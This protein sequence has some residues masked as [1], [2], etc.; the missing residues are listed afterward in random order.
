MNERVTNGEAFRQLNDEQKAMFRET[1]RNHPLT[2]YI[3]WDAF[4][5]SE[6]GNALDFVK[7]IE[8]TVDESGNDVFFLERIQ[9]DDMDY[10]LM[11]VCG[12]NIFVKEPDDSDYTSEV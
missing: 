8:K 12:E 4:Y 5:E 11:F 2:D 10:K 1:Y 3:D 9:E 7:C 6:N